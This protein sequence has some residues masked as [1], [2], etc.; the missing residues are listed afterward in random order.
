[1]KVSILKISRKKEVIN[2][3]ELSELVDMIRKNPEEKAVHDLR[4]NYQFLKPVRQD[5]GQIMVDDERFISLPR[6]CFAI[7]FDKYKEHA[8]ML[9]YNGLTVIEMNGLKT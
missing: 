7:E 2:R 1:M 9:G 8:R 3:L 4:L 5:D 6:I